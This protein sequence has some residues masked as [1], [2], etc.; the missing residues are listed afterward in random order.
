MLCICNNRA[1]KMYNNNNIYIV[2]HDFLAFFYS[3]SQFEK[4]AKQDTQR[5]NSNNETRDKQDALGE[6]K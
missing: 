3:Y 5:R 1:I 6:L 4:K 2:I